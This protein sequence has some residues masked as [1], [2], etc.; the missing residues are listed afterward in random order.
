MLSKSVAE[1]VFQE[2]SDWL[3]T[4]F[5]S[6]IVPNAVTEETSR[7]ETDGSLNEDAKNMLD[8]SVTCD[9][10]QPASDPLK[11]LAYKNIEF[12][13]VTDDVFQVLSEELKD[14]A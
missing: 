5:P 3:K 11:A 4:V 13:L 7:A 9:V 14:R 10:S 1:T 2:L 12:M 8:M 6:N